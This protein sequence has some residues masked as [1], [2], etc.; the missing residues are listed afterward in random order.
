MVG[1]RGLGGP[2]SKRYAR[3]VAGYA[4]SSRLQGAVPRFAGA[5]PSVGGPAGV[6][7]Y[8]AL[9]AG[10]EPPLVDQ[11]DLVGRPLAES[12]RDWLASIGESWSQLTFYLFDPESWR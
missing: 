4:V 5:G 1:K 6:L 12:I 2:A 3:P 8:D 10:A 9:P 7:V 11:V